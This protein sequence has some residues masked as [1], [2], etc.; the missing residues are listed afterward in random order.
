MTNC[1]H[2]LPAAEI[3]QTRTFWLW[4]HFQLGQIIYVMRAS[5]I[6]LPSQLNLCEKPS[7]AAPT[8][9]LRDLE[10]KNASFEKLKLP[11]PIHYGVCVG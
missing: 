4:L 5:Q 7:K 3:M 10:E 6:R 11:T 8:M 2:S 1:L 9:N